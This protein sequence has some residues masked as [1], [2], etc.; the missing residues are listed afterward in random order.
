MDGVHNRLHIYPLCGL[1]VV[2]ELRNSTHYSVKAKLARVASFF[3]RGTHKVR[4][5]LQLFH[6]VG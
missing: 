6:F 5:E 1:D 3:F 2:V 4:D